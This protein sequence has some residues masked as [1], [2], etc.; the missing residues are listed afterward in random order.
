MT[1]LIDNYDVIGHVVQA[2][3]LKNAKTLD[4]YLRNRTMEKIET[5]H[6]A[7]TPHREY[8]IIRD[9]IGEVVFPVK[10]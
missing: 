2:Q 9:I 8:V 10:I 3:S 7:R 5:W 1:Y 4:L 6:I